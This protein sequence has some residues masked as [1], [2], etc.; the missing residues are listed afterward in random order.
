MKG[1]REERG[2]NGKEKCGVKR[3]RKVSGKGKIESVCEQ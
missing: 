2:G 3:R 1:R